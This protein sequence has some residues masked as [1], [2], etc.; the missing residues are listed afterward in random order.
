MWQMTQ[1]IRYNSGKLKNNVGLNA[2]LCTLVIC[3]NESKSFSSFFDV[4]FVR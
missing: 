1:I 4:C 3:G 2:A